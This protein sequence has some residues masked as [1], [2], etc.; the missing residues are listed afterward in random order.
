M[1][2]AGRH[3][4][5]MRSTLQRMEIALERHRTLFTEDLVPCFRNVVTTS[6]L[7]SSFIL[8]SSVLVVVEVQLLNK[9]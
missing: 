9:H 4:Q 5:D 3:S 2:E 7:E 1:Q 6:L 8:W